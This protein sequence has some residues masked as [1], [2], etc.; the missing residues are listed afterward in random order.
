[1]KRRSLLKAS[2]ALSTYGLPLGGMLMSSA[3]SAGGAGDS[4]DFDYVDA[5]AANMAHAAYKG[6]E[7]TLPATLA[8]LTPQQ[9]A[10]I[11]FDPEKSLW[12]GRLS[13]QFFHVGMGFRQR[14]RMFALDKNN[15]AQEINFST[16]LFNYDGAGVDERAIDKAGDLGFAGFKIF[17]AGLGSPGDIVAFLGASYFRAVDKT[18]QYGLSARGLAIDAAISGRS[19]EFPYF[20]HFWFRQ[21]EAA[22]PS[23]TV[24]ALL[25]SPS[26]TGAYQF[27]I[28]CQSERVVMT[29]R[30]KLHARKTI[31]H[32]GIAPMTSMFACGTNE[33]QVCDTIHPQIHDSDRLSM[34]R[35][36]GEWICRPLNNPETL[37]NNAFVDTD[38]KGFGLV[39]TDHDFNVYQDTIDWYSRRPSLWIEP[40]NKWGEGSVD[41][42]ELPTTGETSDNIVVYWRPKDPVAPGDTLEYRYRLYWSALPP[43]SSPLASVLATRTGMGGF[44]EGWAPGDHFP[45]TWCRRFA[46]DF[47]GDALR[48]LPANAPITPKLEVS[49]G[50]VRD[51]QVLALPDSGYRVLFDWYPTS[52]RMDPVSMRLYI[53]HSDSALSETWL[54]QY[55]PPAPERRHSGRR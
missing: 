42:A 54:Y 29:V 19:E 50:D 51:L 2:L 21:P 28:D 16:H 33:R 7:E 10:A 23:F 47:T 15:R 3:C 1:M 17:D 37:Q 32:L 35:G 46:I 4:V 48:A 49:W 44:T 41:L 53:T 26:A 45:T 9:Y 55:F 27:D 36:N 18:G 39:Q 40:L 43:V 30:M 8:N 6:A 24:Y 20:T 52:Q 5:M 12:R 31:E 13:A 22:S 34:W 14:V 38:P 25:D 11:R